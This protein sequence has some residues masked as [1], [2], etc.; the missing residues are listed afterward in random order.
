MGRRFGIESSLRFKGVA[1]MRKALAI[2]SVIAAA[3]MLLAGSAMAASRGA[4]SPKTVTVVMHDPGCHWF[5]VNGK[6]LKQL[7]V[8]GPVALANFDEATL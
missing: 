2:T 6:F 3:L 4:S 7:S 8:K 5:A 1:A